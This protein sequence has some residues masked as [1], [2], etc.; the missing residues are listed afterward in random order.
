M[1]E[2][3]NINSAGMVIID[4][5]GKNH[6]SQVR[7]A[8]I[9]MFGRNK[10]PGEI[11]YNPHEFDTDDKRFS[12]GM[13]DYS[14]NS[15]DYILQFEKK[16][17][18]PK[19]TRDSLNSRYWS[20]YLESVQQTARREIIEELLIFPEDYILLPYDLPVHKRETGQSRRKRKENPDYIAD[21]KYTKL[22]VA[23][24]TKQVDIIKPDADFENEIKRA[25]WVPW[26]IGESFFKYQEDS[27]FYREYIQPV[28]EK[29]LQTKWFSL[30]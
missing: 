14:N 19:G 16:L 22:Y 2:E 9:E 10:Q 17:T 29:H 30:E 21:V 8:L 5:I 23:E 6:I 7:V 13:Y 3:K 11:H 24:L 27:D 4:S 15:A 18:F 25:V 20:W 26:W 1:N 28:I 12:S